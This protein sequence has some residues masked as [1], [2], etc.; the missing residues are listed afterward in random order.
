L[1]EETGAAD[2]SVD[3]NY[4]QVNIDNVSFKYPGSKNYALKNV[5]LFIENGQKVAIVGANG[6]GKTTLVKLICGLY[7]VT[8]GSIKIND[9]VV[10]ARN[11]NEFGKWLS[12]VF[13]DFSLFRNL[14][15]RW[16]RFFFLLCNRNHFL[17]KLNL[18]YR[19]ACIDL[20]ITLRPFERN[21]YKGEHHNVTDQQPLGLLTFEVCFGRFFYFHKIII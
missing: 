7:D 3:C 8:K 10:T 1:E 13:Q 4:A 5:S 6:S 11:R 2:K 16:G 14:N 19:L 12:A 15:G 21:E 9:T 17:F 18:G 20:Y